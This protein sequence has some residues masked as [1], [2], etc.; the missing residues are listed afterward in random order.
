PRAP[1]ALVA[2]AHTIYVVGEL[3]NAIGTYATTT[4]S[5]VSLVRGADVVVT[6]AVGLRGIALTESGF[7]VVDI[8]GVLRTVDKKGAT[9][10]ALAIGP[11][12]LG[13]MHVG[14]WLVSMS[15]LGHRIV[16][17]PLDEHDRIDS[18]RAVHVDNAGPFWGFDARLQGNA[19]WLAAGHAEDHALD[20]RGGSF[21]YI[22]SFVRIVDIE[23]GA[24]RTVAEINTSEKGVV[25]PK[26]L[27]FVD[28]RTVL[29]LGAGSGAGV[30][31]DIDTFAT[32]EVKAL[33]GISAVALAGN[34]VLAASPLL[35]AW[36]VLEGAPRAVPVPGATPR[37]VASKLG[38]A[39]V[40]TTI[41]A[42]RQKSDA[43]LSRFTCETCHFEGGGDGRIHDTGRGEVGQPPITATTKPLF[44]LFNNKPLFTR[45]LDENLTV[46]AHAEFRV[47]NAN[48]SLD[49]WF[50]LTPVDA[51]WLSLLGVTGTVAPIEM[52]RALVTFLHDFTPRTNARA[53]TPHFSLAEQRGAEVF[54]DRCASC[55]AARLIGDDA[56]TAQPFASWEKFILSDNS[57][58]TWSTVPR[59]KTGIEPYVHEEGARPTSLRRIDR[60]RPYFTNGSST[61]LDDVVSRARFDDS[62]FLHSSKRTDLRALSPD[63]QRSLVSF[64]RLL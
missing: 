32:E 56:G 12:A 8:D 34:H 5:T 6:D 54:R 14:P 35:D 28:D 61:T 42:P 19:L 13:V 22:D 60:K 9:T 38:E 2:D 18:A 1:R 64:L 44:G 62:T 59:V 39:L 55:H 3:S 53:L 40:F 27:A 26:A 46:M 57:P 25:V 7:A 33:P 48:S 23:G 21:G 17:V 30:Q 43:E 58:L 20:R 16:A 41:M 24:A 4:S 52:R 15:V 63:D 50:A 45:A 10:S 37:S 51:P 31:I 36:V 11:G 47:A 49:P 29:A